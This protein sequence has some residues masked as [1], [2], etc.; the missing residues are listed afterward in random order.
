MC[1]YLFIKKKGNSLS[2]I[3]ITCLLIDWALFISGALI[4]FLPN[5][6]ALFYDTGHILNLVIFLAAPILYI[7]F[8]TL[9]ERNYKLLRQIPVHALP[10]LI[11]FS[12]IIYQTFI[13]RITG[14]VFYPRAIFLISLLFIQ[15]IIYYYII[16]KKLKRIP[17]G[18]GNKPK[19]SV[20]RF[21]ILSAMILFSL[22]LI[23]F[24][25]WNLMEHLA[26]CIYIT[27]I[28]FAAAFIIINSLVIFSLI[29]PDIM[30]GAEKY[31]GYMISDEELDKSMVAIENHI[32]NNKIFLD[33]LISLER[34]SKNLRI[35]EKK[36]SQII[37]QASGLNF[38]DFINKYRILYAKK[39][40]ENCKDKKVIEIAF[41]CGFNSKSTF[42]TAFKRH[43]GYTPTQYKENLLSSTKV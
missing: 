35:P 5:H 41:E 17:Y 38:N 20:Y 22:E 2:K 36:L 16:Y 34:L 14:L 42:N 40:I 27:G 3:L 28:L 30:L 7:H 33:P 43:I 1:F 10:F 8:N 18:N 23:I 25:S 13:Q 26:I 32:D 15:N 4:L 11:V 9:F 37:N 6:S 31:T 39:L 24:V 21:L 19:L 29:N 12:Y